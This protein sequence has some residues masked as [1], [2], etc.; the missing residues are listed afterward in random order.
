MLQTG[1]QELSWPT[2]IMRIAYKKT[3][4][5]SL[6]LFEILV[7]NRRKIRNSILR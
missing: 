1:V 5:T 3:N 7:E 2:M 4:T 6:R